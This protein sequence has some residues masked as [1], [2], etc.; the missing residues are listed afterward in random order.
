MPFATAPIGIYDSGLGGLSVVRQL[1]RLLPQ[2]SL[3][4]VADTARVPYGGRSAEEIRCFS[5]EIISYL[6]SRQVKAILC[7]CNTSSVVILPELKRVGHIPVLGLAQAG[8][9]LP[10]GFRRVALLATEATV[11]SHLYRQ[12][13]AMRFPEVELLELACPEF[14]PLVEAGRWEGEAVEAIVRQRLEPVLAWQPEAVILGCSH[15]PYLADVLGRVLGPGVQLLDPATQLLSQLS[16]KLEQTHQRTPYR[17]PVWQMYT[18]GPTEPF[19]SLA[20]RYLGCPLPELARTELEWERAQ[21]AA[22]GSWPM[23]NSRNESL[24]VSPAIGY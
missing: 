24:R 5:Q 16:Q 19:R 6:V 17:A 9:Q 23:A 21:P 22:N 13:I 8:A 7:A 12:L 4:Y 14:V 3:I 2:E 10:R 11:R 20:E 15:Y 18:T 1:Q